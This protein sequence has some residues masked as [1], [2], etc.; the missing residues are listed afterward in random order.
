MPEYLNREFFIR[1]G[2]LVL[3]VTLMVLGE[4]A[5]RANILDREEKPTMVQTDWQPMKPPR[6][7]LRCWYSRLPSYGV[8]YCEPDPNSTFGASR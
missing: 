7:G 4:Q 3:A 2:L 8:S 5:C 1:T 6:S